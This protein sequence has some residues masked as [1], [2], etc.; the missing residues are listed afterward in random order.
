MAHSGELALQETSHLSDEKRMN[1]DLV[2]NIVS[3]ASS[4]SSITKSGFYDFNNNPTQENASVAQVFNPNSNLLIDSKMP[5]NEDRLEE[6]LKASY[7]YAGEKEI[8]TQFIRR[9]SSDSTNNIK[10][11]NSKRLFGEKTEDEST[12]TSVK[13]ND[14]GHFDETT[15]RASVSSILTKTNEPI[16]QDIRHMKN[17]SIHIKAIEKRSVSGVSNKKPSTQNANRKAT[18]NKKGGTNASIKKQA[19]TGKQLKSNPTEILPEKLDRLVVKNFAK[20]SKQQLNEAIIDEIE[21]DSEQSQRKVIKRAKLNKPT[22]WGLNNRKLK[23]EKDSDEEE[24]SLNRNAK[25]GIEK[26]KID[27]NENEL[28]ISDLN[29]DSD[30]VDKKQ[31]T[32][33]SEPLKIVVELMDKMNTS[34]PTENSFSRTSSIFHYESEILFSDDKLEKNAKNDLLEKSYDNS[35]IESHLVDNLAHKSAEENLPKF[36]QLKD[37]VPFKGFKI[38]R[39][40]TFSYFQLPVQYSKRYDWEQKSIANQLSRKSIRK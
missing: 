15:K 39:A 6:S 40:F 33:E 34:E 31:N 8:D 35:L 4:D 10:L 30:T 38:T 12:T 14:H 23:L 17:G 18:L 9:V 1:L 29:Q 36:D 2:E 7:N 5:I 27:Q 25:I 32:E 13:L 28:F 24:I 3:G 26:P 20:L 16:N 21:I 11:S 19:L 22:I 37:C